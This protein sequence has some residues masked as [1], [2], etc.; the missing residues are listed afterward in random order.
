M[1]PGS[2]ADLFR[3]WSLGDLY[4]QPI[5]QPAVPIPGH[6]PGLYYRLLTFCPAQGITAAVIEQSLQPMNGEDSW[7]LPLGPQDPMQFLFARVCENQLKTFSPEIPPQWK[8]PDSLLVNIGGNVVR[9]LAWDDVDTVVFTMQLSPNEPHGIY[10]IPHKAGRS[11]NRRPPLDILKM[12][13]RKFRR[14]V[15]MWGHVQHYYQGFMH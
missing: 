5:D 13:N 9:L 8:N 12:G 7:T 6:P 14:F 4:A 11:D 3:G 1:F 10:H 15:K 2:T